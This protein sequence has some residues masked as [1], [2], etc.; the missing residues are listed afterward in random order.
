LGAYIYDLP[1]TQVNQVLSAQDQSA[2]EILGLDNNN[3]L[4]GQATESMGNLGGKYQSIFDGFFVTNLTDK[5][6]IPLIT[7]PA[8]QFVDYLGKI[9]GGVSAM[10]ISTSATKETSPVSLKLGT[11]ALK[12]VA[13]VRNPQQNNKTGTPRCRDL[14]GS[15]RSVW[16]RSKCSDSPLYLYPEKE[17]LVDIKVNLPAKILDAQPTYKENGWQVLAQPNG[18]LTTNDG[19]VFDKISYLYSTDSE[20]PDYG[21]IVKREELGQILPAYAEMIGLQGQEVVDFTSF[22]LESLGDSPY[23]LVSHFDQNQSKAMMPLEINPKPDVLIQTIMYFQLLEKPIEVK[24]P[25]FEN[26]L[27]R[28]GFTAVDW[29]GIIE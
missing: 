17:T 7:G 4:W 20:S 13:E 3:L 14:F 19:E 23:Y 18:K 5:T 25:V 16:Q 6:T 21:L 12:P 1:S 28:F 15:D 11:F 2:V 24:P 29:S 8:L 10:N 26:V 22:W 9:P 27:E